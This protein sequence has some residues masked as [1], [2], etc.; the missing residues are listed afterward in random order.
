MGHALETMN[1]VGLAG[2]A[3]RAAGRPFRA[4]VL[5]PTGNELLVSL[6]PSISAPDQTTLANP[7]QVRHEG[8]AGSSSAFPAQPGSFGCRSIPVTR[9]R[10]PG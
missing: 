5:R 10:G 4:L 8:R 6:S 1:A 9:R 2:E 7:G 3:G